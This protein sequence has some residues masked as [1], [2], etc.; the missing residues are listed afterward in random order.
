MSVT[1]K[2]WGFSAP[3][4]KRISGFEL[5][6]T[7]NELQ[8]TTNATKTSLRRTVSYFEN[9]QQTSNNK[10][11]ALRMILQQKYAPEKMHCSTKCGA[12]VFRYR[13][14]GFYFHTAQRFP[15]KWLFNC[16]T[17]N[18]ELQMQARYFQG[19]KYLPRPRVKNLFAIAGHFVSYR[20]VSGP[21]NFLVILWNLLK[22]K[23]IVHQQ[24]EI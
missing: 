21:R 23:K 5:Q 15:Q 18:T 8:D 7:T 9:V 10:R 11:Q 3:D 1:W 16:K 12:F 13:G 19:G 22:S 4:S 20:W 14:I 24:S 6:N 2:S 17:P